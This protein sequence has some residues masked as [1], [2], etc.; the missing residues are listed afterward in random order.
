MNRDDFKRAFRDVSLLP[1]PAERLLFLAKNFRKATDKLIKQ[2]SEI[3]LGSDIILTQIRTNE[4]FPPPIQTVS[5]KGIKLSFEDELMI[6]SPEI[7]MTGSLTMCLQI[8]ALT[9]GTL[10]K[11]RGSN[12]YFNHLAHEFFGADNAPMQEGDWLL[13]IKESLLPR[14]IFEPKSIA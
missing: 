3:C 1:K 4:Y 8:T 10:L 6:I 7:T 11:F 2:L 9:R 12:I 5:K 14:T 13:L